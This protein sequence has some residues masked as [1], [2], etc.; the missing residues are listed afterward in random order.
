MGSCARSSSGVG[1]QG[2]V[3]PAYVG[4][5]QAGLMVI[6]IKDLCCIFLELDCGSHFI[7]WPLD[8]LPLTASTLQGGDYGKM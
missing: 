8:Q 4:K 3:L 2:V 5:D 7:L 6:V 1:L